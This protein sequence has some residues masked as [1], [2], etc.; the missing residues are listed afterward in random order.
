MGHP[1]LRGSYLSYP[2]FEAVRGRLV[3]SPT[4]PIEAA[5]SGLLIIDPIP[6]FAAHPPLPLCEIEF[7][8]EQ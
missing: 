7:Q 2:T 3:S 1:P 6:E 8:N 5:T 4:R